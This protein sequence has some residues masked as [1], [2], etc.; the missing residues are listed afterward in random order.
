MGFVLLNIVYM[1]DVSDIPE[2]TWDLIQS[3]KKKNNNARFTAFIVDCLKLHPHT[4]HFGFAQAVT[5]AQRIGAERTYM[6]GFTHRLLH[7]E[8][9]K[10]GEY[11]GE[12]AESGSESESQ[13]AFDWS[14]ADG[15]DVREVVEDIP[16]EPRIWIR[17]AYDGLQ[18]SFNS[19][20]IV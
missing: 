12:D 3:L 13:T 17:P 2:S 11:F 7:E 6:V 16:R 10:L 9:E 1:S 8:W 18:F 4:S 19:K 5:A 15:T 14:W 20:G